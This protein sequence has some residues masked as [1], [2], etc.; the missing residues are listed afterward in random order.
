MFRALKWVA[1]Y[2]RIAHSGSRRDG[3]SMPFTKITAMEWAITGRGEGVQMGWSGGLLSGRTTRPRR[4]HLIRRPAPGIT[5]VWD[6]I[7][8]CWCAST[9]MLLR[10]NR[11]RAHTA[12]G[13]EPTCA[14]GKDVSGSGLV[15]SRVAALLAELCPGQSQPSVVCTC[16]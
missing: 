6:S 5:L 7:A 2:K 11:H 14:I 9:R 16:E 3:W 10:W 8:C 12:C 13:T 1:A 4:V 15:S